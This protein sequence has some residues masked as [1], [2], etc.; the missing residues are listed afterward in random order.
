MTKSSLL[1]LL[2][3]Y[4]A[5]AADAQDLVTERHRV[6][7]W[8]YESDVDYD[9]PFR[10]VALAAEVTRPDG[11][12]VT[13]PAYWAGGGEWT[14]RYSG[15]QLGE[16]TFRTVC[17]DSTDL[18]L[19]GR[20]GSITVGEYAGRNPLYRHGAPAA[21]DAGNYLAHADGTPF[22]WL[23]DS[24]WHGMTT[25]LDWP[26]GFASLTDD[27]KGKG[28]SVIQFAVGFPCDIPPFDPRGRNAAGDPWDEDFA[29]IRPEYFDLADRRIEHLVDAGLV[30]NV[31]GAWGYYMK[32]AGVE[33]MRRHWDYLIARYGAYPV[34]W[35]LAGESTLAWYGDLDERWPEEKAKLRAAW[36]QVAAHVQDADPYDRLLTVHPGPNSGGLLPIDSTDRLDMIMC[37]S[38]H[39]GYF[40][41]PQSVE[42]V[43][44][45][46]RRYPDKPV[47]HGEVCFEGMEGKS[48]QD[49]QR[50][51][52]WSSVLSGAPGFSYGAEGIWQFNTA[53]EPFGVS[54]TGH[55]WG[56]VPW[57]EAMDYAGSRQVGLSA[58]FLREQE[59]WRLR[60]APARVVDPGDDLLQTPYCAEVPGER[61]FVYL[62]RKPAPWKPYTLAG[63]DP[64]RAYAVTWFDPITGDRQAGELSADEAGYVAIDYAP[65][66]QDW[67]LAVEL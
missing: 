34:T 63:F 33:N 39:A 55:V 29:S 53:A 65:V 27:R 49:V 3:V 8:T 6:A 42:F 2:T 4:A 38:G 60:P 58:A 25:R 31:V 40:S 5:L 9:D 15:T 35:T 7:E 43:R 36:S 18:G 47:L 21:A 37:Q 20:T 10:E 11:S 32:F 19:H 41:L 17:N 57:R 1:S 28:F 54:P 66:M 45:A 26:E 64:G 23:A 51:A 52:F 67:V 50:F 24:W 48:W 22:F 44:E 61:L 56:N 59:W 30:P 13:V 46:Q 62:F 14:F 16:H 12:R